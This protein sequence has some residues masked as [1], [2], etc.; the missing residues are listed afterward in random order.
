MPSANDGG[1]ELRAE[2]RSGRKVGRIMPLTTKTANRLANMA[3]NADA[4]SDFIYEQGRDWKE[5]SEAVKAASAL[6][7]A[8][9]MQINERLEQYRK[10]T[11]TQWG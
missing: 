8:A 9:S 4:I 1:I 5:A 6:L 7:R 10:A 3:A 11:L 2:L